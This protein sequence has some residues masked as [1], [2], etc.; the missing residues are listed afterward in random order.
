[1]LVHRD[2]DFETIAGIRL[3]RQTRIV[4]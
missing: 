2:K 4:W 1:M 3:L